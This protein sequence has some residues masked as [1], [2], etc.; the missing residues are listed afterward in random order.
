[1]K[2]GESI[3]PSN[4]SFALIQNCMRDIT[5]DPPLP[6]RHLRVQSENPKYDKTGCLTVPNQISIEIG[7]GEFRQHRAARSSNAATFFV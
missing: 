3:G 5:K 1:M 4:Q 7:F 6:Y 2:N